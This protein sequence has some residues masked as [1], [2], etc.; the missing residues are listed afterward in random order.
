MLKLWI[1][2]LKLPLKTSFNLSG[3]IYK[4]LIKNLEYGK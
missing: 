1:I 4:D 3:K 2:K